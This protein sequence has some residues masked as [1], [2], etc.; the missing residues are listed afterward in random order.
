VDKPRCYKYAELLCDR[1]KQTLATHNNTQS[2]RVK[3]SDHNPEDNR[4][5]LS[6]RH[7]FN[8][9]PV[10]FALI[11]LNI[12]SAPIYANEVGGVSA[13]ANPVANSSGSVTN[14]A[15]QVLQGPYI[16]NTYGN[17][18]QCQ[19][20]TLNITPFLTLSDSWKEPYES[21]YF[22]PVYDTS[23]LDDD[24]IIDN[25]GS[26]LYYVPVRT[27]Q[28]SNHNIGWGISATL[29]IPL[30]RRHNQGCLKAADIQ[31]QYHAQLVANKRLDFEIS[32]LK[33]CAEQ[34]KLGVSFHPKS[35][36]HQIC[37]DIVVT[38]PHGVIPNHQHEI[39]K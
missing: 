21:E 6:H 13:T 4:A 24:G 31:N 34:R 9:Q 26:V 25:P 33:H 11:A 15:I 29:S 28:K 2:T 16:T 3:I 17:G 19:G 35:P 23:D 12:F 38:N 36:S 5:N 30:D 18:V 32:R 1:F 20:S 8:I 27:G 7:G 39:P 10:K 22:E 37:A 14:Q